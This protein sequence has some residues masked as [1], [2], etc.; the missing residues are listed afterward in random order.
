MY[1]QKYTKLGAFR[2]IGIVFLLIALLFATGCNP[3]HLIGASSSINFVI[4]LGLGGGTGLLNPPSGLSI[5]GIDL[6]NNGA[7]DTP[8]PVVGTSTN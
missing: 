5:F 2:T 7:T 6:T 8:P 1:S 4:P 3:L